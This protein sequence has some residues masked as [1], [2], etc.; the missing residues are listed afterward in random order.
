MEKLQKSGDVSEDDLARVERELQKLTD[1]FV[2]EVE[3]LVAKKEEEL[4]E[5]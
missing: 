5:V 2:E 4:L 1:K 3:A